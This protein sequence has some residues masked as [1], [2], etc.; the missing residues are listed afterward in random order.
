MQPANGVRLDSSVSG[1]PGYTRSLL[2]FQFLNALNFTIALGA[3]MVLFAKFLGARE[4]MI[5][6]LMSLTPFFSILQLIAATVADRWGYKRLMLAGWGTRAYLLCLLCPLPFL[7]GVVPGPVLLAALFLVMVGFNMSRGFA[8][9]SWLP[10]LKVI[11]PEELRGT[12]FGIEGRTINA[13]VL[14]SLLGSSLLLGASPSGYQYSLIIALSATCGILSLHFLRTMPGGEPMAAGKD[15]SVSS[16]IAGVTT[17]WAHQPFRRITVLTSLYCIALSG[18]PGFLVVYLKDKLLFPDNTIMLITASAVTGSLIMGPVIGRL[19]DKFGSRPLMR[20]S[21]TGHSLL[22]AF[23]LLLALGRIPANV[24][25]LA[26]VY[27]TWGVLGAGYG[28][29]Q[30]RFVLSNCPEREENVGLAVYQVLTSLCNGA[31]PLAWGFIIE[32]MHS[33]SKFDPFVLLFAVS[34]V[35]LVVGNVMLTWIK[36]HKATPTVE[37]LGRLLIEWPSRLISVFRPEGIGDD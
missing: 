33:Y 12:Y 2:G 4:S 23:W 19:S 32:F 20:L 13:G 10:W 31:A 36:E 5:G 25:V 8:S 34:L 37:V 21:L 6:V 3:P 9:G 18:V 17:V 27:F 30:I 28:I 16:L 14:V 24:F 1:L 22:L 29:P 7:I 15:V 26:V 35:L 11:I